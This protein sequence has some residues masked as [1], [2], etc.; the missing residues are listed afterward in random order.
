MFHCPLPLHLGDSSWCQGTCVPVNILQFSITN[1][2]TLFP[3]SFALLTLDTSCNN[4]GSLCA[5]LLVT[6]PWGPWFSMHSALWVSFII[7]FLHPKE[8]GCSI[9]FNVQIGEPTTFIFL[10]VTI[11]MP[12]NPS[13]SPV[14]G[15]FS[16]DLVHCHKRSKSVSISLMTCSGHMLKTE[17]LGPLQAIST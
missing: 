2:A 4:V 1:V 15:A 8:F 16:H 14:N 17:A 13:S 3:V 11:L 9:T 7:D 12:F 10:Q 5:C 6:N